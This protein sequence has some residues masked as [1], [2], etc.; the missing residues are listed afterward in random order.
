M[1]S[2][3]LGFEAL[4]DVGII[5]L[6]HFKNPA[7]EH[8]AKLL[9]EALTLKKPVLI[10]LSTYL[11]AYVIMTRYLKLRKDSVAKALLKTLSLESPA[12]YTNI[13]KSTVEKAVA[14]ASELDISSWDGYL[15]EL[16]K[17]L[18]ISKIYTIDEELKT[19]VK[20]IKIQNPI[21]ENTMKKYHQYIQEKMLKR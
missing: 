2:A 10:P 6:A 4:I 13:P 18:G 15:I 12:F 8:A 11:G 9:L 5:V 7:R 17:E 1:H 21:P 3:K 20:D 19:K 16:A 14:S